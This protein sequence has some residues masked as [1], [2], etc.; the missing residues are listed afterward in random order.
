VGP[1]QSATCRAG[2]TLVPD[3][4]LL[5]LVSADFRENCITTGACTNCVANQE[6]LSESPCIKKPS[7]GASDKQAL[8]SSVDII[9]IGVIAGVVV[10]IAGSVV[11]WVFRKRCCCV[12]TNVRCATAIVQARTTKTVYVDS[13]LVAVELLG[14]GVR[15]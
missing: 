14:V 11:L 2:N 8:L 12:C 6:R 5:Q 1:G 3:N 7:G 13:P 15:N 4:R 9:I 10:L